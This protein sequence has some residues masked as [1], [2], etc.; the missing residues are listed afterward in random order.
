MPTKI[1]KI[2][3]NNNKCNKNEPTKGIR[4]LKRKYY[5]YPVRSVN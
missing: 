2:I 5:S 3:K 4:I 1:I